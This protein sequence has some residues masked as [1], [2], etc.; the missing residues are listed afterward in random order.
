LTPR[1]G[2]VPTLLL[3]GPEAFLLF[4]AFVSFQHFF[5]VFRSI[6]LGIDIRDS[7]IDH[8]VG[9][10]RPKATNQNV[11]TVFIA[12]VAKEAFD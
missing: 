5:R 3:A 4:L 7:N 8:A 6:G 11:T 10:S 9:A 12:I 2:K 1:T